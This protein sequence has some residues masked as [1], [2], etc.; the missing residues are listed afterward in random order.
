MKKKFCAWKILLLKKVG[1]NITG[2]RVQKGFTQKR[3]AEELGCHQ[4]ALSQYELGGRDIKISKL[5]LIAKIL[6]VDFE[7]LIFVEED[8]IYKPKYK[9]YFVSY[10]HQDGFDSAIVTSLRAK[11]FN[12]EDSLQILTEILA[13]K[14]RHKG[15]VI[16]FFKEL[17]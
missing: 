1:K 6:G 14:Y 4:V 5:A 7:S 13:K 8:Q 17:N 11:G 3:L 10:A 12:D 16:L 9:D 15:V 2:A